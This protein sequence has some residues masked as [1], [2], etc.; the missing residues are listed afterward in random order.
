MEEHVVKREHAGEP[1]GQLQHA[2]VIAVVAHLVEREAPARPGLLD[3]GHGPPF[4]QLRIERQVRQADHPHVRPLREVRQEV[5]AV[6]GDPRADG[7]GGA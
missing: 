6:V 5:D 4:L 1:Q 7:P 2:A 3:R